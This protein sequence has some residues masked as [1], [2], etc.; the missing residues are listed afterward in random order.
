MTGTHTTI[1]LWD[2]PLR[3]FHWG[4][5]ILIPLM[6]WT[7]KQ[8]NMERHATFGLALL[9]LV[10][11]RVVWGLIGSHTARF[12]HFVK[13]PFTI[14]GYLTGKHDG[15]V[16]GHNPLG[17]LSVIGLLTVLLLQIGLGLFS[18][19]TDGLFSGPLNH[20][21]P[22]DNL[23]LGDQV[24]HLHKLGFN[25]ILALVGVHLA[26]ILFYTLVKKDRLVPPMVTGRKSYDEPVAQPDI[27]PWWRVIPALLI[28]GAVTWWV[29]HG[30]NWPP[31]G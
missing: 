9:F 5:V 30:A 11:F 22:A 28:A 19:D 4:V 15:K 8:G 16:V 3:L 23:D 29:A 1:R 20:Y 7:Y 12:S 21:I 31:F 10:I 25:L 26:A 18:Q 2:L 14:F 27:A 24:H 17:A 13:G 6:W